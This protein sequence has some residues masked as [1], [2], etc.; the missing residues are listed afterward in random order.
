MKTPLAY[1]AKVFPRTSETFV[2]NEMRALEELG[3]R[4]AMFALH[5][6]PS[7]VP[8]AIV[9]EL[10]APVFYVEDR[11]VDERGVKKAADHLASALDIEPQDRPRILPRKYVRLAVAMAELIAEHGVRHLHAHFASRSGH[12]AALA[13]SLAGIGYSITAHA[14]DIYHDEVDR[15]LLAW[16]IRQSRFVITVTEFNRRHLRDLAAGDAA[17]AGKVIRLY[18]GVDLER[19][20]AA[21]RVAAQP[22]LVLAIGRLIEKKGFEDLVDACARVRERDLRFAC[23]IIGGG[24]LEAVLAERIRTLGLEGCVRLTGTLST[25]AV[26]ARLRHA[27]IVALPCVVGHDGNVDALPTALLEGMASGAALISTSISGI[28]EIV[29]DGE[30]GR[31]VPPSDVDELTDALAELIAD[32]TRTA[33]MGMAGRRRAEE[34]FDLRK[35]VA[36]LRGHLRA[37]YGGT[38]RERDGAGACS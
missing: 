27:A 22:P 32:P 35:N 19:F 34:L 24:E 1:V 11:E 10:A 9:A 18:N 2:V 38:D 6:N 30:N 13:A 29:V 37:A 36:T 15:D 28:P 16:K 25:E 7:P 21:G 3:E 23:E 8:H 12:V 5:R 14:K 4:P 17:V 31:L 20:R 33:A 26:A